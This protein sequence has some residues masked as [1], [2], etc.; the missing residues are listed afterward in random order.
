MISGR[1]KYARLFVRVRAL[2]GANR[3]S[4]LPDPRADGASG[5]AASRRRC[6]ARHWH[7]VGAGRR[8]CRTL[9]ALK[10]LHDEGLITDA[11]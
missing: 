11:E 2:A 1:R 4:H 6:R 3:H 10:A 7:R 8:G 5:R 9:R